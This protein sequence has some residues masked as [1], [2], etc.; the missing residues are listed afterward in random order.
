MSD[1]IEQQLV[2]VRRRLERDR[3]RAQRSE[4]DLAAAIR[5]AV[6]GG[7]TYQQVATILGLTRQR[8]HQIHNGRVRS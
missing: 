6:D 2:T 3:L 4:Q 5:D 7:W 1:P 8:V